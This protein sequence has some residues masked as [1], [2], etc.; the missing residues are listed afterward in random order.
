MSARA[1]RLTRLRQSLA[2]SGLDAL[3]VSALPNIR[4]LTGFSGSN[5]LVVVTPSACLLLTD[6]RYATQV[7]HEVAEAARIR[8]SVRTWMAVRKATTT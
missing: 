5:A 2:A 7:K 4:Y 6:F 1:E 8:R 3:L